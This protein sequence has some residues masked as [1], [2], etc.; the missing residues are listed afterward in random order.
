MRSAALAGRRA[1]APRQGRPLPRDVQGDGYAITGERRDH[2]C[3]IA[4]AVKTIL[5]SAAKITVRNMSDSD[6]F[7]EQRLGTVQPHR[8]VGT[9]LLHLRK[10][11]VPAKACACKILSLH[12]TTEI[13]DAVFHR[14]DTAVPSEASAKSAVWAPDSR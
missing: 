11:S 9:V 6:R 12:H 13:R 7:V 3:L 4:D 14:L 2:G 5:S 10:E 8:E 1:P